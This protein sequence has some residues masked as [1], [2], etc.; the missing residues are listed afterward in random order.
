MLKIITQN[1]SNFFT[2]FE[3]HNAFLSIVNGIRRTIYSKVDSFAINDITFIENTSVMHNEY[4]KHRISLIPILNQEK[5][6]IGNEDIVF[7]LDKKNETSE[8]LTVTTNDIKTKEKYKKHIPENIPIILLKPNEKLHFIAKLEKGNGSNHAKFIP[9]SVATFRNIPEIKIKKKSIEKEKA[10][11]IINSCPK[12]IFEYKNNK[13][14]SKNEKDCIFCRECE[15][16]SEIIE[17]EDLIK[18]KKKEKNKKKI[19]VFEIESNGKLKT[20][21]ILIKTIEKMINIFEKSLDLFKTNQNN[22]VLLELGHTYSNILTEYLREDKKVLFSGYQIPHP[23]FNY[24]ILK[25]RCKE[26]NIQLKIIKKTIK[27]IIR[28]LK[29]IKTDFENL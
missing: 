17:I 14:I 10:D 7:E 9:V 20:K 13:I 29:K 8:N 4:I 25:I 23:L 3:V 11:V 12:K 21:T 2:K 24:S 27:K 22:Y 5:I 15:K 16:M 1:H 26:D 19:Y 28:H 6:N 18:I